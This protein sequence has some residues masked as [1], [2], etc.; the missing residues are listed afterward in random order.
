[1]SSAPAEESQE[2][3]L[4]ESGLSEQQRVQDGFTNE[5]KWG[6]GEQGELLGEEKKG[7]AAKI[8]GRDLRGPKRGYRCTAGSLK[9]EGPGPSS[10]PEFAAFVEKG[11][12]KE[13]YIKRQCS[14][15][16]SVWLQKQ[17]VNAEQCSLS[18]VTRMDR[19]AGT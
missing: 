7:W 17:K 10:G 19:E 16:H 13:I 6:G 1:M 11:N 4:E 15:E 9:V 2:G 8:C 14:Q 5:K 12:S 18:S 3:F